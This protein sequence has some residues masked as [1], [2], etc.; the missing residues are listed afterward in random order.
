MQGERSHFIHEVVA[1]QEDFSALCRRFGISRKTGYKWLK[2]YHEVGVAG[3]ADR[4]RAPHHQAHSVDAA[5]EQRILDA[6][7]AHP[8]WGELKLEAWLK[9]KH[10][11]AYC[12]SHSTIGALLKRRGLT[13]P[14][15][16]R[17]RATPSDKLTIGHLPNQVWAIDFKGW[18]RTGDSSRCDP[19]TV[20]DSASRFLLRCQAIERTDTAH[21]KPLME[22]LFRENGLPEVILSDNGAPFSSTGLAGL[23]RRRF[24]PTMPVICCGFVG[25]TR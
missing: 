1:D 5:T 22:A 7:A 19:L 9:R 15:K 23:R 4:S 6:R 3:L 18:F 13:H 16:R 25:F 11:D 17:Q 21:V 8:T 2:R 14:R 24:L 10:P 20:S 12:P